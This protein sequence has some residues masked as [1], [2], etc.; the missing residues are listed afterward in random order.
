[1]KKL[2]K[3]II[4]LLI[5]FVIAFLIAYSKDIFLMNEPLKIYHI[6][7]DSFFAVGVVITGIGLFIYVTNEGVFDIIAYGVSS[8]VN[9]FRSNSKKKYDTFYDYRVLRAESKLKF[10]FILI[11][12]IILI[13]ISLIF[14]WLYSRYV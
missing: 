1:M 13:I 12:G 3:Y 5:G 14:Y 11:S 6:L 7:C 9:L 10:G 8:F 4:T 2:R